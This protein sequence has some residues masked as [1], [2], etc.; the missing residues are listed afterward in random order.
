[1]TGTAVGSDKQRPQNVN[2]A[3]SYESA[4]PGFVL[5]PPSR[6]MHPTGPT[7]RP[8]TPSTQRGR[9]RALSPARGAAASPGSG[10]EAPVALSA[11]GGS[12]KRPW[13]WARPAAGAERPWRSSASAAAALGVPD[14]A[15][16]SACHAP[17]AQRRACARRAWR[18]RSAHGDRRRAREAWEVFEVIVL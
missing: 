16:C 2:C 1:M 10:R 3:M 12:A 13:R 9:A 5:R 4:T 14:G 11:P 15:P 8:W 7:A 18:A 6:T 17:C